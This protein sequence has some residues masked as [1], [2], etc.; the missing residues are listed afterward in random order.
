MGVGGFN[1]KNKRKVV[2]VLQF[3]LFDIAL[4][5]IHMPN[6]KLHFFYVIG[7][8]VISFLM[9]KFLPARV[10][11]YA[12]LIIMAFL[13]SWGIFDL[14][15]VLPS[16]LATANKAGQLKTEFFK[17]KNVMIIVPHEDDE[18]NLTG[19]VIQQYVAGGSTVRVV[20]TTNGDYAEPG[21]IR[22][23]EAIK[24]LAMIGIPEKNIIFLGYGDQ[25]KPQN[26]KGDKVKHIYNSKDGNAVW[27]SHAGK[28]ATYALKN[29]PPFMKCEYTR[30]S[31]L[32]GMVDV[33]LKYR[34]QVIY[35]VDYDSHIDHRATDLSFEEAM[36]HILK[37]VKNYDPAVFK[38]FCYS[39]AWNAPSDFGR[40]N[41]KST[42]KTSAKDYMSEN[43]AYKWNDR[44]RIPVSALGMNRIISAD[45]QYKILQCEAE[46]DA[47]KRAPKV[48]NGDK[49]FWERKT[50]SLLYNSNITC[51]GKA[52]SGLND[53]KLS[54]SDD[55]SSTDKS[56]DDG[57]TEV[58]A[59]DSIS[60]DMGKKTDCDNIVI[61][62]NPD[63]KDNIL[64]GYIRFDNGSK[65]K[66]PALDANGDGTVIHCDQ[67]GVSSF[68][69]EVTKS[70][71]KDAGLCEIE[72]YSEED[73]KLKDPEYIK[74]EDSNGDFIY[75]YRI[76]HGDKTVL[77]LYAYPNDSKLDSDKISV[78][79]SNG[80]KCSCKLQK[81]GKLCVK[82]PAG[83]ECNLKVRYGDKLEDNV[84][85]SN[86]NKID[87]LIDNGMQAMDLKLLRYDGFYA[88]QVRYYSNIAKAFVARF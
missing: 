26:Q 61:Y 33:I 9:A 72:A 73:D 78:S 18:I 87:R 15:K 54:D 36:G 84:H 56:P 17:N 35:A 12:S 7:L 21:K 27:T 34:P 62:D 48:I 82:C 40:E 51:D 80:S 4:L 70:V 11:K 29:H 28:K 57:V 77:S 50:D 75:D 19:G 71:G 3:I 37:S 31:L 52:V 76:P 63:V 13:V 8:I 53:F 60:V 81:D 49:V 65:V 30:N 2:F 43:H 39:T 14:C 59:D 68:K 55:I 64:S 45:I 46:R 67:D 32:S 6:Y 41:I 88:S 44:I 25:W 22:L 66:I 85:I 74:L 10:R 58:S 38:G 16:S 5:S 1:D 86:P 79:I 83:H 47:Y 23:N 69:I 20:F 24:S 42:V